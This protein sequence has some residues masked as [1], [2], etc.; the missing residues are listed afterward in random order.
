V[1][2]RDR[3]TRQVAADRR[4]VERHLGGRTLDLIFDDA[5]AERGEDAD[6]SDP[7]HR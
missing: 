3:V 5:E 1:A 6:R 4:I 2:C 7:L